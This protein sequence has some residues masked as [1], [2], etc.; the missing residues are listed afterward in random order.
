[1]NNLYMFCVNIVI[2]L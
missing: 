2:A 1:M